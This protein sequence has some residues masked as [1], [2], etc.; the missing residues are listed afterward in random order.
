MLS[1]HEV[2]RRYFRN[3]YRTGRHGWEVERPAPQAVAF[4]NRLRRG[5]AGGRLL[6][7]GCGEGRHSLAAARL[8][9]RV[10]GIDYEPLAL[11]RARRFA[12][13]TRV[14]GVTYR[15]ADA[16]RLPFPAASFDIVLDYGCFHHQRKA[17]WPPYLAGIR[18]VLKPR[19]YYLLSVFSPQFRL[20][21]GS[22]RSWHVAFGA[23][24]RRFTQREIRRIFGRSFDVMDIV[25]ERGQGGGFWHALMRRREGFGDV[26][27]CRASP[28]SR[29]FAP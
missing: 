22:R 26:E 5:F 29:S 11:K 23:Y 10:T 21:R 6:D 3:A 4:L 16:L 13:Q 1:A 17:D 20:F 24:R 14:A 8:G 27:W 2:N 9:F 19:G 18:R 7:V 12:K 28:P 25:A 15:Q